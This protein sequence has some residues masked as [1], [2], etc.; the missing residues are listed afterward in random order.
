MT[1][2]LYEDKIAQGVERHEYKRWVLFHMLHNDVERKNNE[3]VRYGYQR[4]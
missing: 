2:K 4:L 3:S 1:K